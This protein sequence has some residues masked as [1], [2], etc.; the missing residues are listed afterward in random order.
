MN[1]GSI[2][3]YYY[4]EE[5]KK[6]FKIT[7]N[8]GLETGQKYTKSNVRYEKQ[9]A[10]KRKIEQ[11]N[12]KKRQAQTIKRSR[13]LSIPE[14]AGVGLHRETGVRSL[15]V[16]RAHADE[17]FVSQLRYE[18]VYAL[19]GG[20]ALSAHSL[21]TS[22]HTLITQE[23][24]IG[25][26]YLFAV[27]GDINHSSRD[28][29]PKQPDGS[30]PFYHYASFPSLVMST[31]V[32]PA[33]GPQKVLACTSGGVDNVFIGPIADEDQLSRPN[34]KLS[35]GNDETTLWDSAI[36]S[37]GETAAI[38]GSDRII[39]LSMEGR[40]LARLPKAAYSRSV[41]WLNASTIAASSG[42]KLLLWDTRNRDSS[43]RFSCR[44]AITGVRTVPSSNGNQLLL[45][46]NQNISL[47]DT[48]MLR[49]K[50][51]LDFSILH[52]GPQLVFDVN[53]RDLVAFGHKEGRRD[54]V[55]ILSLRTGQLLKTLEAPEAAAKKRPTQLAWREDDRG[56][57]F[58]QA[59]I[60]E[61]IG[62]WCWN[63]DD[64]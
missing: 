34:I 3:G 14:Y 5:K 18:D 57:E 19:Q 1:L 40:I 29:W 15:T 50:P 42:E 47:Q 61:R 53:D 23:S 45:S 56:V 36:S 39:H 35:I 55:H 8:H 62:R 10:K 28:R 27:G 49:S 30:T 59:C 6:Y 37:T 64:A 51:V 26:S 16:D 7:A 24:R 22:S 9:V 44:S 20:N 21:A 48:R 38:G 63:S 32:W 17:A 52:E 33:Q 41:S 46:T 31:S 43:S 11:R 12:Q 25:N 4:D 60:G 54:E 58:L 2:P 13:L